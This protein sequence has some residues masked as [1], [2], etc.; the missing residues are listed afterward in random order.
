MVIQ[1]TMNYQQ[2]LMNYILTTPTSQLNSM[3]FHEPSE[4]FE[5]LGQT[6]DTL[7]KNKTLTRMWIDK[8]THEV[9]VD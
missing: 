4:E 7:F 2:A 9:F 8:D 6:L 1:V 3:S 5:Q